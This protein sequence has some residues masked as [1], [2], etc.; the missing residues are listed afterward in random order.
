M[1][2]TSRSSQ[3]PYSSGCG[4]DE[5]ASAPS[6][7]ASRSIVSLLFLRRCSR[8]STQHHLRVAPLQ[9]VDV[10]LGSALEAERAG[11]RTVA[12]EILTAHPLVQ[13]VEIDEPF[14]GGEV[15]LVDAIHGRERTTDRC[16][17]MRP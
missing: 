10:V 12:G 16:A 15:D 11:D 7:R 1:P 6:T 2:M 4:T 13:T 17:R 9:Q 8:R 5:P 14:Q 3:L